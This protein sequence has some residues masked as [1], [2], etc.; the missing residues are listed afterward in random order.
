[1]L[2]YILSFFFQIQRYNALL[3]VIRSS[4]ID[5]E[6]GI[7]GLVVMSSDLEEIF[8]CIHDARV[9]PMWEK[10]RTQTHTAVE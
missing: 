8:T 6:K 1:M 5:L 4:L 3:Q 7:K 2:S 9:P 10:V